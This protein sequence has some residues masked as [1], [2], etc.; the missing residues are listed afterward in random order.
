[1]P[2]TSSQLAFSL[3]ALGGGSN[4]GSERDLSH[5]ATLANKNVRAVWAILA[6]DREFKPNHVPT[7]MAA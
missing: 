2:T 5:L 6:H 3:V 4:T 7:P 1:M